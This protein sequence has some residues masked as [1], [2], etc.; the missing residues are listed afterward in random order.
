MPLHVI[1]SN[2]VSQMENFLCSLFEVG[3][4][5]NAEDA[6]LQEAEAAT[7]EVLDK[8]HPFELSPQDSRMR[9]L[10]HQLVGRY[11]LITESKGKGPYRR[12]VI[13]PR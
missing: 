11:G 1:R 9:R 2:T 12:L 6:A 13:Y 10:Q 4:H 7:I 8:G 3:E 5:L